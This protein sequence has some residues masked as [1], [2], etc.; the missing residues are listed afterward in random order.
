M[1]RS[2]INERNRASVK[3]VRARCVKFGRKRKLMPLQV[4]HARKLIDDNESPQ[5][6]A[7]RSRLQA[8]AVQRF[9]GR[10]PDKNARQ[11]MGTIIAA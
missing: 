4:A 1:E 3:A 5:A 7:T 6:V 9:T 2:L 11:A 10:W 8:L